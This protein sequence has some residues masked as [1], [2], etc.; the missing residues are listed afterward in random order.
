VPFVEGVVRAVYAESDSRQFV[1]GD[2]GK[3]VHGVWV[4]QP[5]EPQEVQRDASRRTRQPDSD[6]LTASRF[7][8]R[9][10]RI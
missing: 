8:G 9:Q 2:D 7:T 1:I 6:L 5:G 3:W 10:W 4:H